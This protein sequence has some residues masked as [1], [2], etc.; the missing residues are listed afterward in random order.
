MA[1]A[2]AEQAREEGRVTSFSDR[3]RQNLLAAQNR[4]GMRG[5]E[6]GQELSTARQNLAGATSEV[7]KEQFSRQVIEAEER[8]K[9]NQQERLDIANRIRQIEVEGAQREL[10]LRQQSLN[11]A[12]QTAD[13]LRGQR[14]SATERFGNLNPMQRRA[15]LEAARMFNAGVE[16]Q[17]PQLDL[18]RNLPEIFGPKLRARANTE[19]HKSGIDEIERLGGF[20]QRF[21]AGMAAEQ[22]AIGVEVNARNEIAVKLDANTDAMAKEVAEKLMPIFTAKT[23][24]IVNAIA[25]RLQMAQ[26]QDFSKAAEM[27]NAAG[28]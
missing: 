14:E 22:Q 4:A 23:Q 13:N 12:K 21:N 19:A 6:I 26:G 2:A 24:E 16:L 9:Q 10:A 8:L 7:G 1:R 25:E 15:T 3:Q 17:E 28:G 27:A 18:L 5:R 11:T 20:D